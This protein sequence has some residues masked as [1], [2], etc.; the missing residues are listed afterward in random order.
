MREAVARQVLMLA[1][2]DLRTDPRVYRH[3]IALRGEYK[4]TA[5]GLTN[6]GIPDV[7][8]IPLVWTKKS[9]PRQLMAAAR[10]VFKSYESHYWSNPSI[11]HALSALSGTRA[12]L[13]IANDIDTLPLALK[14]AGPAPVIFDAHEY[15]PGRHGSGRRAALHAAYRSALCQSYIPRAA[16]MVTVSP[17]IAEAYERDTTVR[18]F[19]IMNAPPFEAGLLPG[20]VTAPVKLVHHGG[21]MRGR[22]L[23]LMCDM[24]EHLD[25]RFTLTLVLTGRDEQY[26][27]ELKE[28][29][30]GNPRIHFMDPVPM[31]E[32]SRFLNQFDM[33]VYILPPTSFNHRY[34]LPNKLFEFIQARLAV[35][36]GPSPEMATIVKQHGVGLVA[37]DFSPQALAAEI[38]RTSPDDIAGFKQNAHAAAPEL[39]AETNAST[40][41]ALVVDALATSPASGRPRAGT[42]L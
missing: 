29:S 9:A 36:I 24:M 7:D 11:R 28:R 27:A 33:G 12:D 22:Q 23:E 19:V 25:A 15:W 6:P 4:V 16:K 37:D 41:R 5:A 21:A 1:F 39:S 31:T 3:L 38:M 26:L 10:L 18:P 14:V 32:I 40:L 20:A 13:V 34:A 30:S 8:F 17:G 2:T 42:G 35:A